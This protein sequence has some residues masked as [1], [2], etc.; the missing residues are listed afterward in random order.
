LSPKNEDFKKFCPFV[1]II[2]LDLL[3]SEIRSLSF[4]LAIEP[5]V[6][7]LRLVKLKRHCITE[8]SDSK[9][10]IRVLIQFPVGEHEETNEAE[11]QARYHAAHLC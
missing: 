2:Y 10:S 4:F 7:K 11:Q 1:G 6:L 3:I 5:A 8:T 9:P